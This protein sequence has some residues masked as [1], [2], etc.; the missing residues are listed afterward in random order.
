MKIVNQNM[1][2]LLAKNGIDAQVK[3]LDKGSMKGTWRIQ[4]AKVTWYGNKELQAKMTELGFLDYSKAPLNDF[5]GN[6][7]VFQV[8]VKYTKK[9]E[10]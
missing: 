8:F 6:G 1:K 9:A 3:Y 4:N 2:N 7:G 5:S 10:L